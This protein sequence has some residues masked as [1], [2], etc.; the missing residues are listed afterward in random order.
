MQLS[1]PLDVSFLICEV[2][3][4][5]ASTLL[6]NN[7][8]PPSVS[9]CEIFSGLIK[10]NRRQDVRWGMLGGEGGKSCRVEGAM[11]LLEERSEAG[12]LPMTTSTAEQLTA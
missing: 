3:L 10:A 1:T 11:F 8:S 5:F 4:R 9:R 2:H 6:K 7:D 12:T